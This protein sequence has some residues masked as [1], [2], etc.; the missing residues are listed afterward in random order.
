MPYPIAKLAYGLR[1]RLAEISTPGERYNF[2]I[3]AGDVS[4][5]PTKLQKITSCKRLTIDFTYS[6]PEVS[7][8]SGLDNIEKP[9]SLNAYSLLECDYYLKI[10]GA[11]AN[12]L[13]PDLSKH[14][15]LFN[16]YN[17]LLHN[18]TTDKAFFRALS[19]FGFN[20]Y[21]ER[22]IRI[23]ING[24]LVHWPSL[25][26]AF[27]LVGKLKLHGAA[28]K[29]CMNSPHFKRKLSEIELRATAQEL[30]HITADKILKCLKAQKRN[31]FRLEIN[32]EGLKNAHF[33]MMVKKLSEELVE[34][35][36]SLSPR[37]EITDEAET[38][39]DLSYVKVRK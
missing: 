4:I 12:C 3:A 16:N 17:L 30:R 32:L 34:Y 36:Y 39:C 27:P 7:H 1:C 26:K 23:S 11:D 37:V 10:I 8:L 19:D 9:I 13:T 35:D 6:K 21:E 18:C 2:Q 22:D 15:I 5:C 14:F 33:S 20:D 28:C 31:H 24:G 29:N 38:M 25:Y